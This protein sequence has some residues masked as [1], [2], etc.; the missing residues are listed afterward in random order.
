MNYPISGY[1]LSDKKLIPRYRFIDIADTFGSKLAMTD[2][3]MFWY[4][5]FRTY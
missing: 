1:R 5:K 2:H 4:N 3:S